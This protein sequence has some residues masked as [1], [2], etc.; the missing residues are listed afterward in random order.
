[1]HFDQNIKSY[2]FGFKNYTQSIPYIA[3]AAFGA[4]CQEFYQKI[5]SFDLNIS[6]NI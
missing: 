6:I 3:S 2:N 5:F 4:K 1:M